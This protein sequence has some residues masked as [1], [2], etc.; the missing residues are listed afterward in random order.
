MLED[1]GELVNGLGTL[2]LSQN[3][4]VSVRQYQSL[5]RVMKPITYCLD[6]P[7]SVVLVYLLPKAH[8]PAHTHTHQGTLFMFTVPLSMSM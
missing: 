1:A 6:R 8:T 5:G 2:G 4:P 7:P 3:V